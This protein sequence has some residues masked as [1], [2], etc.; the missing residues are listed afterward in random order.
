MMRQCAELRK[1]ATERHPKPMNGHTNDN[2]EQAMEL[3]DPTSNGDEWDKMDMEEI[4][5]GSKYGD[6]I[7]ET[8][9][10]GQEIKSEFRDE[11]NKE[12][13][14]LLQGIFAMFAYEDP[15]SSPTAHLLEQSGRVVVA[16]EINSAILGMLKCM[17][18]EADGT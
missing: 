13:K 15:W 11:T 17:H 9:R 1:A 16:E 18:L 10:Y 6:K 5:N 2:F 14:D 8:L 4:D 7:N 3:D 12:V